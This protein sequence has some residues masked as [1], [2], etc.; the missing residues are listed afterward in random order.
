VQ[1]RLLNQPR[2]QLLMF[3]LAGM[4]KKVLAKVP[5]RGVQDSHRGSGL[6]ALPRIVL[7]AASLADRL[8]ANAGTGC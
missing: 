5:V 1:P 3:G 2:N 8:R 6:E 7:V 4:P